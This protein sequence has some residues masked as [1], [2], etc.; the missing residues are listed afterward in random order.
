MGFEIA[1][2]VNADF[3][4][5]A[6]FL[7][8]NLRLDVY[9][10]LSS[11]LDENVVRCGH[12]CVYSIKGFQHNKFLNA[13]KSWWLLNHVPT[14]QNLEMPF[15]LQPCILSMSFTVPQK[16]ILTKEDL[17]EFQ[18]SD[19]YIDFLGFIERLNESVKGLKIDSEIEVSTVSY[20]LP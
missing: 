9:L 8:M 3:A 7:Q 1:K 12:V 2:E 16:R 20:W 13:E 11:A 5:M 15:A 14:N 10:S 6:R 19:A 4:L 18:S 17:E